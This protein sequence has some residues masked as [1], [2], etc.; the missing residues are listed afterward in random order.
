M[1]FCNVYVTVIRVS[2]TQALFELT[3]PSTDVRWRYVLV[4]DGT[5]G[6]TT[7]KAFC[8]QERII[9]PTVRSVPPERRFDTLE[10]AKRWIEA[11]ERKE[12]YA[13]E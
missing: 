3:R 4:I 5:Q 10:E 2:K 13:R 7:P 9:E 11:Y 12:G 6:D 8:V 1:S